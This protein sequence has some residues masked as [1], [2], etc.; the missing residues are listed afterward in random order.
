M[1]KR[2]A[3]LNAEECET[4][5]KNW[6]AERSSKRRSITALQDSNIADALP[7]V[8]LAMQPQ[9]PDESISGVS[10]LSSTALFAA[11]AAKSAALA[12]ERRRRL[13]INLTIAGSRFTHAA[14]T[15]NFACM[16]SDHSG[17]DLTAFSPFKSR[18]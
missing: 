14:T 11:I 17:I 4:S 12:I 9:R 8:E 3:V 2:L 7:T 6:Q 16:N 10:A 5:L 15:S 18:S 1:P 13:S